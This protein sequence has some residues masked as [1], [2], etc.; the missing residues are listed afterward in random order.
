MH[1]RMGDGSS[2]RTYAQYARD[3]RIAE[4]LENTRRRL[5]PR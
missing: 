2:Q 3:L 5:A 1:I 4:L